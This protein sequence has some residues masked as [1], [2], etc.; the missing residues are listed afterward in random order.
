[1]ANEKLYRITFSYILAEHILGHLGPDYSIKKVKF[2]LGRRLTSGEVSG[3]GLYAIV[4]SKNDWVLRISAIH[5]VAHLLCDW[6]YRYLAE[7]WLED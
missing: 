6:D 7:C 2:R 4:S 1:M 5:E 3:S